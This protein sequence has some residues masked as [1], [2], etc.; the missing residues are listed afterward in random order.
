M[1]LLTKTIAVTAL[2]AGAALVA[3][4]VVHATPITQTQT[5]TFNN[6]AGSQTVTFS[7]FAGPALSLGSVVISF[8]LS[9]YTLNDEAFNFNGTS[10]AVGVP[11]PLSATALFTVSASAGP[12]LTASVSTATPGFVGNVAPGASTIGTVTGTL[13]NAATATLTSP[14]FDLSSYLG[15]LN[16]VVF[17]FNVSGNQGGSVP[18]GVFTSNSGS[19]T[20]DVTLTY[21]DVPEP[22]SMALLGAGLLGLGAVS[23]RRRAAQ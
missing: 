13:L 19:A 22:A 17:D 14:A 2:I 16:S 7:G 9:A 1:S 5:I 15:G 8:D 3:A 18:G 20:I 6:F 10:K 12:T 4:P 11:T 23:R 21:N